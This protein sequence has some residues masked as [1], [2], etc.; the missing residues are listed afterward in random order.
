MEDVQN[1]KAMWPTKLATTRHDCLY[2]RSHSRFT[3]TPPESRPRAICSSLAMVAEQQA[4]ATAA[5]A[6]ARAALAWTRWAMYVPLTL[7]LIAYGR[8]DLLA[9][10]TVFGSGLSVARSFSISCSHPL[11]TLVS[12]FCYFWSSLFLRVVRCVFV[13]SSTFYISSLD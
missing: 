11:S 12:Y 6:A 2:A 13:R 3:S 1:S 4:M 7:R 8:L 10:S 5:T 9:C